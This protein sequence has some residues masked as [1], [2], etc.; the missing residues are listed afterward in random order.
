MGQKG[1]ALIFT[2]AV[3]LILFILGFAFLTSTGGDYLFAG[4]TRANTNAYF[5]AQAGLIY[6]QTEMGE[7]G[8][9]ISSVYGIKRSLSTGKF[10]L[11]EPAQEDKNN[12]YNMKSTGKDGLTEKVIIAEISDEGVITKWHQK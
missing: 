2:L 4:K 9:H 1:S 12:G 5:L 8:V 11:E 3:V 6:A 10:I 7:E